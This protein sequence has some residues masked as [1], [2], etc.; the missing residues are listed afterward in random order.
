MSKVHQITPFIHVPNLQQALH[1]LCE[2]LPFEVKYREPGYAYLE[3]QQAGLRVLE[4]PTRVTTPD[5]KAR[6]TVYVDV[7]DVDGL[8]E[9]L[10][11]KLKQLPTEMVEMPRDKPWRQREFMVRLPDGDWIAFGQAVKEK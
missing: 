6:M 9:R 7:T 1:L 2:V 8:Y 5:G 11:P 10:S 4:E 3:L